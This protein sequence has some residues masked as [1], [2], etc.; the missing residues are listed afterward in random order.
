VASADAGLTERLTQAVD[1]I[2]DA[3]SQIRA[4]IFGLQSGQ[5]SSALHARLRRVVDDIEPLLG[6]RPDLRIVGRIDT[7]AA[8]IADDLVA[9]LREG[10]TNIVRHARATQA[11]ARIEATASSVRI[12][13]VDNGIGYS[14]TE[15]GSGVANLAHRAHARGGTF[16]VTPR[17]GGG[18]DLRW[19][20]PTTP[21]LAA[22]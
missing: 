7:I 11:G 8:A 17:P 3:I 1:S 13:V 9:C 21:E 4:S 18:T 22:N 6:F 14:P 16:S 20:V 15:R 12:E 2:D 5:P 19:Q 10:L